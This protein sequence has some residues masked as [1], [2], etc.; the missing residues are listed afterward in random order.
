M[1][2]RKHVDSML[3]GL[4][5]YIESLPKVQSV[6]LTKKPPALQSAISLWER[7]YQFTLP[8][9]YKT[10]LNITD[11]IHLIWTSCFYQDDIVIG[12]INISGVD[13]LVPSRINSS[14]IPNAFVLE[15]CQP[16]GNTCMC[17]KED[18]VQIWFYSFGNIRV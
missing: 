8:S 12:K 7:K 18:Q 11:G 2:R 15:E 9:D 1:Q 5:P 13:Q 3:S 17:F 10:F 16:Y 14:E 6:K 4:V